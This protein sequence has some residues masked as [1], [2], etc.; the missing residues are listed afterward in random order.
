MTDPSVDRNLDAIARQLDALDSRVGRAL[1]GGLPEEHD[2]ARPASAELGYDDLTAYNDAQRQRVGWGDADLDRWLDDEQRAQLAQLKQHTRLPW[3]AGDFLAVGLSGI[4]GALAC[5]FDDNVDAA[6]RDRLDRLKQWD[7]IKGWERDAKRMPIDYTGPGFGGPAHRVRS[8]GHDIGRPFEALRQ[9]RDGQFK[10]FRWQDGV[11]SEF[12]SPE[13]AYAP[14]APL[15]EAMSLWAKHLFADVI[16]PMSLPLPGWTK[17]YELD[18]REL[19]KFAHDAYQGPSWGE[20]LN[21][22]SG[23]IS[24]ALAVLTTEIIVRSHVHWQVW[25]RSARWSLEPQE[26]RKRTEML[27]AGHG[28]VGAASLASALGR[29]LAGEGPIAVRHISVPVLIRAGGNAI[30]LLHAER[31]RRRLT[32]PS[33]DDLLLGQTALW[34]LHA[35]RVL[36]AA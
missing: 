28:F 1:N 5:V 15:G 2:G 16:T 23:M 12:L 21:V 14:V 3:Q 18:S 13:G 25:D 27:L 17:L 33:W 7:V 4:V 32:P 36:A 8:A 6:V 30:S 29:G 26:K 31:T 9:I 20:G 34:D 10:G 22:R 11:R 35:A 24:P 19:R